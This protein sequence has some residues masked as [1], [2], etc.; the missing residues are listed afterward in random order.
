[1]GKKIIKL[2]ESQLKN[3]VSEI[4]GLMNEQEYASA[5][6]GFGTGKPSVTTKAIKDFSLYLPKFGCVTKQNW[7]TYD[8][9]KDGKID[10]I[11]GTSTGG[12]AFKFY[13][14]NGVLNIDSHNGKPPLKSTYSCSG[15]KVIDSYLKNPV[16]K[17]YSDPKNPFIKSPN[18]DM[19]I[20]YYTK[21]GN[22]GLWITNLQK[23]LIRL[24]FL[25]IPKPTGFM[26]NMTKQAILQAVN[27]YNSGQYVNQ[28]NGIQKKFYE[29]LINLKPGQ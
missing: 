13:L 17:V 15:D 2:T 3:I 19:I 22:G 16:G 20:P 29:Q 28:T 27:K 1:M 8:D 26:G 24:G 7:N 4:Y 23:V 10:R 25:K 14:P 6:E 5:P 11:D 9:N 12:G 21:D 18:G